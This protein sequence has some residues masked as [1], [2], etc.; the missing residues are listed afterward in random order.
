MAAPSTALSGRELLLIELP[1]VISLIWWDIQLLGAQQS[2][3]PYTFPICWGGGLLFQVVFHSVI[4][5]ALNLWRVL[6]FV[7]L[8]GLLCIRLMNHQSALLVRH[9]F[10]L[11]SLARC[12]PYL[13]SC[14]NQDVRIT[15]Y[16]P[17][18]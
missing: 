15:T 5:L 4:W 1:P 16:G 17:S 9:T 2:C 8:V 14:L 10:T 6:N 3:N 18:S 12:Q 11:V 13:T 7:I